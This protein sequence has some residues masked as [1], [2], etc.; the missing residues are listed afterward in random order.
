MLAACFLA[1]GLAFFLFTMPARAESSPTA[2]VTAV[3]AP[4]PVTPDGTHRSLAPAVDGPTNTGEYIVI[5][6][7][8]GIMGLVVAGFVVLWFVVD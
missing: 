5:G 4:T 6:V 8:L 1:T 7:V 3:R 2:V